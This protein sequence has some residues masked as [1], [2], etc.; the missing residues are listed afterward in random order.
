M[1]KD[2]Q[3]V[4]SLEI[5]NGYVFRQIFELYTKLVV[6]DIPI[7][8]SEDGITIRVGTG[9]KNGRK[10]ISNVEI[11]ADDIIEYYFD[12]NFSDVKAEKDTAAL[13]LEQFNINDIG[14]K[15]KSIAK[16]NAVRLFKY[17]NSKIVNIELKGIINNTNYIESNKYQSVEYDLSG[18]ND[19]TDTPNIK[20]E[21][22]HFCTNMKGLT[23]GDPEY[24]SFKVYPKG[25]EVESWNTSGV[26]MSEGHWGN[27]EGKTYYE[28]KVNNSVIK[29]L[30][31]IN[32]MA[33]YSIV[34][35]YSS[36]KGYLKLSHKIADFGNHD[37]FLIDETEED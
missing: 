30:C 18:F 23:R 31:K 20:I 25:L 12:E 21:I 29:A 8:F 15:L 28:T 16:T 9:N 37:I 33:V 14:F 34:K 22:N 7:F 5:T 10:L 26:K 35:I 24:I 6:R 2:K 27:I 13:I 17:N 3:L 19:I 1:D 4:Y 36:K 32:S 11:I